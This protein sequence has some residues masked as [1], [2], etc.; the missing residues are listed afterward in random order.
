MPPWEPSWRR[1]ARR[2]A[3]LQGMVGNAWQRTFTRLGYQPSGL[4]HGMA[5][6][7]MA[8]QRTIET[9]CAWQRIVMALAAL[10]G[11]VAWC[12]VWLG[13]VLAW[14]VGY[15]HVGCTRPEGGEG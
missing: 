11:M 12:H 14:L 2:G 6:Y 9:S 5:W 15:G 3:T 4:V 1:L 8:W 10:P 13:M 7:G